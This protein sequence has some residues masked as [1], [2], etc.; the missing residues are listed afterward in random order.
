MDYNYNVENNV[1]IV[2]IQ[3]IMHTN[4]YEEGNPN[5]RWFVSAW[6]IYIYV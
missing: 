4:K 5:W 1:G 3:D 2:I 6:Y